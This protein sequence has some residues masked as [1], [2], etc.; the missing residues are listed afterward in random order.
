MYIQQH[1]KNQG[2]VWV[3]SWVEFENLLLVDK[4]D[5]LVVY[6]M[7]LGLDNILLDDKI[8]SLVLYSTSFLDWWRCFVYVI[9]QLLSAN[10]FW[11]NIFW[12]RLC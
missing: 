3:E 8:G 11:I 5:S 2:W 9:L 7:E 12:C 10:L 4:F 6:H 1:K